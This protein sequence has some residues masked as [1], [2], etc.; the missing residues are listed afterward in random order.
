MIKV[1]VKFNKINYNNVEMDTTQD[2]LTFKTQI[3]ALSNVPVDSQK[4]MIKGKVLKDD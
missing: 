4:I 2:A 1:N 3:Y